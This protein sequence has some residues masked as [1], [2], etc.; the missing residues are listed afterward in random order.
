MNLLTI[1]TIA[2]AL[3][4]DAF[5]VSISSGATIKKMHVRQALRVALFFGVFQAV[6]PLLGWSL[7]LWAANI[8]QNFDHWVAFILLAVVGG[9]MIWESRETVSECVDEEEKNPLNLSVL[10]ML[11]F[12][13]SIDAA[14]VGITLSFLQISILFPVLVIGV[15]TFIVSFIGMYLGMYV[16]ERGGDFFSK[17]IEFAGGLVLIGIGVKILIEHLT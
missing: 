10:I 14:A 5:A 15:I 17:K 7:G 13:T 16:C 12:A 2:F 9:K 4:M 3:A 1:I 11:S 6:M 8:I